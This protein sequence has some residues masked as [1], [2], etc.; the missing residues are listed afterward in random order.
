GNG[1]IDFAGFDIE[2]FTSP[3]TGY[4]SGAQHLINGVQGTG[5]VDVSS[6][7]FYIS[8]FQNTQ[9]TIR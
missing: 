2:Y 3:Y 7:Q 5:Y 9:I 4:P 6:L 8:G 1:L